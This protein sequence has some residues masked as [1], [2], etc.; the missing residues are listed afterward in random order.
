METKR[1]KVQLIGIG[2]AGNKG[3]INVIKK[4][5]LER[6]D[7]FLINSTDRD[8]EH[9]YRDMAYIYD[10]E[11]GSGK[12]MNFAASLAK[13]EL[14]KGTLG[15]EL[16]EWV[17]EDTDVVVVTGSTEGGTNAGSIAV[18]TDFLLDE[19]DIP[20]INIFLTGFMEDTRGLRN[21]IE[22]FQKVRITE[23]GV[24]TISNLKCLEGK[25]QIKAQQLANDE[26]ARRI[27]ILTAQGIVDSSDN[28]DNTDL[29][30]TAAF[31]GYMTIEHIELPKLKDMNAFN[32]IMST[33][34]HNSLSLDV[35]NDEEKKKVGK[36]AIFLNLKDEK[37]KVFIDFDFTTLR[38]YYGEPYDK[39]K[40]IQFEKDQESYVSVILS[41]MNMP[42][43]ELREIE[44]KYKELTSSVNKGEDN[45]NTVVGQMEGDVED[46]K[47]N[48]GRRRRRDKSKVSGTE[49]VQTKYG[50]KNEK[51][52][53]SLY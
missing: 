49:H 51:D 47:F 12:D 29:Y 11:G 50:K 6:D 39:F 32:D 7:V 28:I 24:Q 42:L 5:V 9:E 41:G 25:D 45:F 36:R 31:A 15:S 38:D 8:V 17:K 40:H 35:D 44:K 16:N 37:D 46:N 43:D 19:L 21:T 52:N 18:I 33:M 14:D 22:V 13:R 48:I 20:V 26:L 4:K 2:G 27:S 1:L 34:I 30:N 53:D 23:V 3:A 10:T